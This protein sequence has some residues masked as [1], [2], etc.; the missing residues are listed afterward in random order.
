MIL[1]IILISC[2]IAPVLSIMYS[3][4]KGTYITELEKKGIQT[5][6]PEYA[7]DHFHAA[8]LQF[9]AFL[10][11]PIAISAYIYYS[12]LVRELAYI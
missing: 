9:F 12:K 5:P 7:E 6:V 8:F 1:K 11:W 3:L 10:F 4:I 2:F